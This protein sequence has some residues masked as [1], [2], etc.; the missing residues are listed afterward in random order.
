MDFD[1]IRTHAPLRAHLW[2]VM[3]EGKGHLGHAFN[4]LM[5]VLILLSVAILPIKF[6][7]SYPA[8][9]EFINVLEAFIVGIFTAE[10]ILRIYAAP[11]RLQYIFSFSGIVDFLS[12]MPFYTGVFHTEYVRVLRL[13]RFLK[14]G[15]IEAAAANDED[16]RMKKIVGLGEGEHVEYVVT[17]HPLF[18]IVGCIP[19]TVALA[20]GFCIL[21]LTD[22]EVIGISIG[23]A[24][25]VFALV[26]LWKTWLDFSYDAIY[27]TNYRLIFNNKHLLG[28]NINQISYRAI[29]NVKPA[30]PSMLAYIFR[31]GS[32]VIDT[33]A[34]VPGEVSISMVREHEKAAHLIMQKCVGI[35]VQR[36]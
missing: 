1:Y 33:A 36:S 18:L 24:L 16:V 17:K 15:E 30:Y 13:V 6:L 8:Y 10:Y 25:I 12:I 35:E 32:L 34:D 4:F 23:I 19:P 9:D 2:D 31:Y 28:R 22:G 3:H 20:F 21:L 5:V 11:R 29:T 26:F 27:L 14:L 7:P